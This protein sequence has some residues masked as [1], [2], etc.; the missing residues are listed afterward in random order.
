[1]NKIII[2]ST[3]L[4]LALVSCNSSEHKHRKHNH[5]GHH[6]T[7][8]NK[9]NKH[10]NANSFKDLA[11]S[12]EDEDRASWQKPELVIQK[13][14]DI[15]GKTIADIGAGTG[16]FS[17]RMAKSGAFV[18]AIDVDKRFQNFINDKKEKENTANLKTKF[19][20]YDNPELEKD[21]FDV[22][23]IVDTYHH[24]NDKIE[25]MTHCFKGLKKGGTLMNVD[26]KNIET[27]HGPPV[28]HRISAN[29]VKNDL[30]KV[31]FTSVEIDQNTLTEQY[32][33]TAKK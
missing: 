26:F 11:K 19:V 2:F 10:M 20:G 15:R 32:I 1:M 33:I 7:D 9:S 17:F 24:F 5:S 12:F 8:H 25:Y 23:L 30:L 13:L 4:C 18:T 3:V 28:D 22:L 6:H 21:E 14:G 27:P 31:G 29:D 16:Y